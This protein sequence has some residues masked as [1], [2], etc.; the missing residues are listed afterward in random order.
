[1]TGSL[2]NSFLSGLS[3][4]SKKD[5]K[6]PL[7][8]TYVIMNDHGSDVFDVFG[9]DVLDGSSNMEADLFIGC[10]CV[11]NNVG[12]PRPGP[13]DSDGTCM[14]H[15]LSLLLKNV[16]SSISGKYTTFHTCFL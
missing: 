11:C 4:E 6:C 1:M 3:H 7:G 13:S 8:F 2:Q 14:S 15:E 5:M 16:G 12:N 9:R 10:G